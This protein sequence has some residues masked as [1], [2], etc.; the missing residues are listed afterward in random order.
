MPN[1]K[2]PLEKEYWQEVIDK[3]DDVHQ[4]SKAL[5]CGNRT[6]YTYLKKLGLSFPVKVSR[7]LPD[8][9]PNVEDEFLKPEQI[10][11]P[12][13]ELQEYIVPK[14]RKGDEEE[15]VL[16]MG[17]GHAGKITPSYD[18]DVYNARMGE[19]FHSMMK[20]ITLHRNM[21]P[22]RKLRILNL[23]DNVQGENPFQGSKIGSVRMGVR[24]QIAKLAFPAHVKLIASLKQ[25]FE[26][27]VVECYGGNHGH[28][29]LAPETSRADFALYDV[30][31]AYF[32]DKKGITIN[33]HENFG[34]IISIQGFCFFCFHGDQIQCHQG[35]PYFALN[36][37]LDKWFVQFDGFNYSC[38]AH[39][40]KRIEDE[41]TSKF[42]YMA[43]ASLVSDDEWALQKLGISSMPSQN[44][45]G[46]HGVHGVTWKYAVLVDKKFLPKKNNNK[47]EK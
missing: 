44:L 45:F 15:A 41:V 43:C 4:A 17:D 3:Y 8:I 24:D 37:K 21:Y 10:I 22:I 14:P 25:E 2:L 19:M 9:V 38:G 46:V 11:L 18:E 5:N 28:E 31:Q 34:D 47:E 33:I 42:T 35:I 1:N 12:P 27:V 36:R 23:G 13:I 39:Y 7:D 32:A 16:H 20:I 40:H 30:L 26:S 6:I 29:R